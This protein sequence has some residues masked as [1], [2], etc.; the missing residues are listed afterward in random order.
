MLGD[1]TRAAAVSVHWDEDF[2]LELRVA[3]TAER[4][5]QQAAREI[6]QRLLLAPQ[7]VE[8]WLDKMEANQ[9]GRQILVRFPEM[10][11]QLASYSRHDGIAGHAVVRCYL[12][13]AAGHN[14]VLAAQLALLETNL[15]QGGSSEGTRRTAKS[16]REKLQLITSMHFP[17]E[18]LATALDQLASDIDAPIKMVGSDLEAAGI[19]KNQMLSLNLRQ[20]PARSILVEILRAANP[21]KSAR[22]AADERQQLVYVVREEPGGGPDVI[23]VTTR[24]AA[25]LRGELIEPPFSPQE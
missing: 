9:Y 12:P 7:L 19:T 18:T 8:S 20:Q 24:A 6:Q 13:A 5:S 25:T 4:T 11:R 14:L 10:L 2:F 17:R 15:R 3:T 16:L 21:D 23:I 1:D 22:D